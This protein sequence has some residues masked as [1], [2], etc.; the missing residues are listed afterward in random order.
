MSKQSTIQN[1]DGFA[2]I[3]IALIMII[4]VGLLSIG[5]A[6]LA[7]REQQSAINDQLSTEAYNASESGIQDVLLKIQGE[8]IDSGGQC[9]S[10]A[11]LPNSKI[12]NSYDVGYTCAIVDT[13]PTENV[14]DVQTNGTRNVLFTTVQQANAIEISWASLAS[15]GFRNDFKFPPAGNWGNAPAMVQASITPLDDARQQSLI[16]NTFS[17]YLY[18]SN[19]ANNTVN[20][21]TAAADQG[22]IVS[23]NCDGKTCTVKITGLTINPGQYFA[24]RLLDYYRDATITVAATQNGTRVEQKDSQAVIDVTGKARNALKRLRVRVPLQVNANDNTKTV[25]STKEQ[26]PPIAIDSQNTC[27]R[28]E[29]LPD[30]TN[31]DS[32]AYG[33]SGFNSCDFG[34]APY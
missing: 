17:L 20:Y 27:K 33:S 10:A 30:N 24:V 28:F 13:T 16:A 25:L 26:L 12:S 14:G 5:F 4:V 11:E 34:N 31:P 1:Q 9:L 22:Q 32:V 29:T 19:S 7:H 21:S 15:P 8:A 6:Q 3:V 2:S 23:G 18:P